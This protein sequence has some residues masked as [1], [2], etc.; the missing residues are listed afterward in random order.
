MI[1]VKNDPEMITYKEALAYISP[2]MEQDDPIK[3]SWVMRPAAN[4]TG[5]AL[6]SRKS[7]ASRIHSKISARSLSQI[8]IQYN[9]NGEM[10]ERPKLMPPIKKL[11]PT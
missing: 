4:D 1:K 7:V 2:N 8:S 9:S 10:K 5:S 3:S 11:V 6:G